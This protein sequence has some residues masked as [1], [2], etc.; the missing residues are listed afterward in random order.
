MTGRSD[1][2]KEYPGFIL[3][4]EFGKSLSPYLSAITLNV[5]KVYH[6]Q[7]VQSASRLFSP[8]P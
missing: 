8:T 7:P 1:I 4:A 3:I 2:D 5:I 6:T